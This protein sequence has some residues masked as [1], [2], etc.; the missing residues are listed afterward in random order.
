MDSAET[1]TTKKIAVLCTLSRLQDGSLRVRLDDVE[2]AAN[3]G[4]WQHRVL[5]TYKDY[6]PEAPEDPGLVPESEL[7]A[8]GH[9]VLV[10][11]LAGKFE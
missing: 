10:R 1:L 11:L 9:Y 4:T 2:K 8:F 5:V 6:Q 3:P 7:A